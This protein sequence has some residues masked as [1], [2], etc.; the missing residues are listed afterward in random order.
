MGVSCVCAGH[1]CWI[2]ILPPA[3]DYSRSVK[4]RA[5]RE[6]ELMGKARLNLAQFFSLRVHQFFNK[7]GDVQVR[8]RDWRAG[9]E[10]RM[11][12]HSDF[13]RAPIWW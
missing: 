1:V 3:I 11:P 8:A 9:P 6:A 10:T 5:L 2:L 7:G 13:M 12:R 4:I